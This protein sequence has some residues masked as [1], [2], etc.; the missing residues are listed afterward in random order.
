[1]L[2]GGKMGFI[3]KNT[4]KEHN[5]VFLDRVDITERLEEIVIDYNEDNLQYKVISFYGM[6]GIGKSR[7]L[8]KIFDSYN[9]TNLSVFH[10]P[11][12][13][14]SQETLPSILF[15]IRKD[16][17]YTPHFDYALFKFW[18]YVNYPINQDELYS[19]YKKTLLNVTD[20]I[21][22]IVF[23]GLSN[24][25]DI[26][27][28]L[29][30]VFDQREVTSEERNGVRNLFTGTTNKIYLYLVESLAKD[31]QNETQKNGTKYLFLFDA[32]EKNKEIYKYCD[33][34]KTFIDSFETGLFIV[35]SREK[36]EWFKSKN[37]NKDMICEC[38]LESIP[39]KEV[40][41]YLKEQNYND[42]QIDLIIRKTECIPLYLDLVIN[43]YDDYSTEHFI[44]IADKNDLVHSFLDHLSEEEQQ[45]VEYFS[46]VKLFNSTVFDY[47]IKFNSIS[48]QKCLFLNF[49]ECEIIRYVE[50][51]KGLYKIHSVLANNI[52]YFVTKEIKEK[53]IIN[54]L[55]VI[56]KRIIYDP[57]IYDE[58]KYNLIMNTY[59]LI[60]DEH[61]NLSEEDRE[62]LID[63]YFYLN[64]RSFG[65][66]FSN[67]IEKI[68]ARKYSH[69]KYVYDYIIGKNRRATNIMAGLKI[70]QSIPI[71]KCLFGKHKK[72]LQC[73]INYLFSIS[74]QYNIAEDKM[75]E[76]LLQLSDDESSE[77]YYFQGKKYYYDMLML[78]GKFDTAVS[79]FLLLGNM[80][81]NK[82][83]YYETQ[84]AIGHCYRFNFLFDEAM[85]YYSKFDNSRNSEV[86]FLTVY[87]E[88][89]CYFSPEKVLEK[90]KEALEKNEELNN[91]NNLGKIHYSVA[92][93]YLQNKKFNKSQ[94][95]LKESFKCFTKTNYQA[96]LIFECLAEIYYEYA[97]KHQISKSKI[98]EI[99]HLQK[100]IDNVYEF[101]LLPIH[102]IQNENNII[103]EYRKKFEWIS[104]D[105]TLQNI[106]LFL[107]RL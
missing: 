52:A 100:S 41:T 34:L 89:L 98:K 27:N 85:Q 28:H 90:Y 12:E 73:D 72:S 84:K 7:L 15:H 63:M 103:Q 53:I 54:Y 20:K 13:I 17:V 57:N 8:K 14:L 55:S 97:M 49:Q 101:L 45:L 93:A 9:E 25:S 107:E 81:E 78:R 50:E 32:Y 10:Y 31:I 76:F 69:Q 46:V 18:E 4:L 77:R 21:D 61:M 19:F 86:Y 64:S 95:H 40:C 38:S 43:N 83:L 80:S 36:L 102:I 94:I 75:L 42:S 24:I 106:K 3:Q 35:S 65:K 22:S 96:G 104:F 70:L 59:T 44:G 51:F 68:P 92:I 105:K 88:S 71:D 56:S 5:D 29:I 37:I 48:P 82:I 91:Y 79:Q 23:N 74:G 67:F 2:M 87:C 1:M 33:W 26:M 99:C 47:A 62:N 11:L 58:S 39:V 60:E 6:G 30:R 66:D 16:F